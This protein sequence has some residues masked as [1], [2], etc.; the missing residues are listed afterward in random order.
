MHVQTTHEDRLLVS[1]AEQ[2][3]LRVDVILSIICKFKYFASL[4]L[5]CP[6]MS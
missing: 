4:V 1:D 3:L 2:N 5:K 6:F